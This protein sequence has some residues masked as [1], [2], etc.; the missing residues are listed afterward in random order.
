MK[1]INKAGISIEVDAVKGLLMNGRPPSKVEA[2]GDS[3]FKA[4]TIFCRVKHPNKV[5]GM[6]K[7]KKALMSATKRYSFSFNFKR[8]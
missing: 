6:R 1:I 4:S 3:W 2:L 7:R 5:S 8:G